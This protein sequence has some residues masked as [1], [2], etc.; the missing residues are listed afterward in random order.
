MC[1]A[2][3][4]WTAIEIA[5]QTPVTPCFRPFF[6]EES[7][8]GVCNYHTCRSRVFVGSSACLLPGTI[9][10]RHRPSLSANHFFFCTSQPLSLW[11]GGFSSQL[12]LFAAAACAARW[13]CAGALNN[14]PWPPRSVSRDHT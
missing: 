5:P 6:A 1:G 2:P 3:A 11:S 14:E 8:L 7:S 10:Q 13:P 9:K 4:R 12:L